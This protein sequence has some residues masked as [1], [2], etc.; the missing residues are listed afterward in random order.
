MVGGGCIGTDVNSQEEDQMYTDTDREGDG[1]RP[2]VLDDPKRAGADNVKQEYKSEIQREERSRA[3]TSV[4]LQMCQDRQTYCYEHAE[5]SGGDG[6]GG[7]RGHK[8]EDEELD[9]VDEDQGDVCCL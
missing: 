7:P 5:D 4:M 2:V 3:R 1:K 6:K 8:T 9:G